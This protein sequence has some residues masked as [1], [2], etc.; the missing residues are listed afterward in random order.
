MLLKAII[1]LLLIAIIIS[2]VSSLV[3][4]FKDTG[5]SNRTLHSLG[6][7]VTLAVALITAIVVGFLSGELKIGAPWDGRKFSQPI[8][9]APK[10]A[11]PDKVQGTPN[12]VETTTQDAAKQT[13]PSGK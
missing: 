7:R 11:M 10:Q 9:Q 6:V 2:L 12:N 4:L 1:I 13:E 8:E 3:F 5:S